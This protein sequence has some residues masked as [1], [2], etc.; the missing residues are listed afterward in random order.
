MLKFSKAEII[1]NLILIGILVLVFLVFDLPMY[2]QIKEVYERLAEEKELY[3]SKFQQGNS[4]D[5][6]LADYKIYQ[7]KLP[8]LES[9][10]IPVGQELRLITKLEDLAAKHHLAQTID[11]S[12]SA[13]Q[14][15]DRVRILSLE[16]DLTG[17]YNDLAAYI[18]E[19][20]ASRF[21]VKITALEIKKAGLAGLQIN[22]LTDSYWLEE[23]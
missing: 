3:S 7:A 16:L 15:S 20:E 11:L 22:L 23:L 12:S 14:F 6:S 13:R 1:K 8:T 21:E 9:S 19:L 17:S 10:F 5:K 2:S 18:E 4:Y